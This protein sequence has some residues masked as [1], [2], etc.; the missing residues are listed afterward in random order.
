MRTIMTATI[1]TRTTRIR[2]SSARDGFRGA[3]AGFSASA[4]DG[5]IGSIRGVAAT[6]ATVGVGR[7][8]DG[9]AGRVSGLEMAGRRGF[10]EPRAG[11]AVTAFMRGLVTTGSGVLLTRGRGPP[12]RRLLA[13]GASMTP[14][15][16]VK[17]ISQ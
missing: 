11:G 9:G 1:F 6:S 13:W 3:F 15:Y 14:P 17:S 8:C 4:A 5:S 10:V 2:I 7:G 16:A 12:L